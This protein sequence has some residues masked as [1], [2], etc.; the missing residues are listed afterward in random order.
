MSE[1]YDAAMEMVRLS[2]Q[3]GVP[4]IAAGNEVIVGFDQARLAKLAREYGAERRP[5]FGV[6]GADAGD[7]LRRHPDAAN[8]APPD[9]N[10]V[11]VGDVRAGS[12]AARAGIQ[13]GDIIVAFAGKRVNG[14]HGLDRLIEAF[15]AGQSASV[16]ILRNGEL[17]TL[18]VEFSTPQA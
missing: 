5:P 10:G 18:T 8:G 14:L 13:R 15:T 7:Y 1:D 2:R 3:Q 11:Y 17:E 9:T 4:V 12:V 16:R 6:L